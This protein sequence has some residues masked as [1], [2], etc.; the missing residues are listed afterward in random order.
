L[1]DSLNTRQTTLERWAP[2]LAGV[3]LAA[4]VII[5]RYPPMTDLPLHE[6][7]VGILRHFGDPVYFPPNLYVHNFGHSNQ[8]FLLLAW[9]LSYVVSTDMACKII[10]ALSVLGICVGAGRVAEHL[11]VTRWAA[12]IVAPVA[13]GWAFFWGLVAN[14]LGMG[15][16]LAA[17]PDLDRFATRPSWRGA[18]KVM[19]ILVVLWLAHEAM[20]VMACGALLIFTVVHPL[21]LKNTSLRLVP[22]F[23]AVAIT[24]LDARSQKPLVSDQ[25]LILGPEFAPLRRKIISIPGHLFGGRDPAS[26]VA[27]FALIG[28]TIG[29][30]LYARFRAHE[31]P[32]RC[33]PRQ[34]LL[35]YRFEMV[36]VSY[37]VGYL[38]MPFSLSGATLVY[39][40]FLMPAFALA[41][42]TTAPRLPLRPHRIACLLAGL[43]PVAT[44]LMVWP[45][46]ADASQS[47]SELDKL[48]AQIKPG[49]A[50]AQVYLGGARPDRV[51]STATVATRVVAVR[52][53]RALF[54]FS[55]S[56]VA[57]VMLRP[58][59][60]WIE[61]QNRVQKDALNFRPAYDFKHYRY[62]ILHCN[63]IALATNSALAM[64]PE[65]KLVDA[66]GDWMLFESTLPVVALDTPGDLSVPDNP[67]PESLLKR[68]KRMRINVAP[69]PAS[70]QGVSAP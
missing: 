29:C 26:Q 15:L 17:L 38:V 24:F 31:G 28:A 46:F 48:I 27:F 39:H 12:L 33:T 45:D 25:I 18:F 11:G 70:D 41:A 42:L 58:E 65:G 60:E 1:D 69:G 44:L 64:A 3:V 10:V 55:F 4:P 35:K 56:T 57:P 68:I 6:A 16:F 37:L 36:A 53:G 50:V 32:W 9:A 67:R 66:S 49:N 47:C 23:F 59:Y 21:T 14:V 63:E 43:L 13:L 51:F 5:A 22:A 40:R 8:L 52:G 61:S 34:F 30:F 20:L 19:A 7:T 54:S 62:V 2:W